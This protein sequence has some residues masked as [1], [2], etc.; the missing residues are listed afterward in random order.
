MCVR[1]EIIR[2]HQCAA[3]SRCPSLDDTDRPT[4]LLSVYFC[5]GVVLFCWKE[6]MGLWCVR[7]SGPRARAKETHIPTQA[8]T[9]EV[10]KLGGGTFFLSWLWMVQ[11]I[12]SLFCCL[13]MRHTGWRPRPSCTP[14]P[15][16]E[17]AAHTACRRAVYRLVVWMCARP[18]SGR[19]P[20]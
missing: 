6:V 8:W 18:P 13:V 9:P 19:H 4:L 1:Y 11:I 12:T 16:G 2:A 5:L 10:A 20:L 14:S 17:N 7:S 3:S 15:R